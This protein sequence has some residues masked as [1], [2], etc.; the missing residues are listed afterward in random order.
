MFF[1]IGKKQ[2]KEKEKEKEREKRK[3]FILTW[4]EKWGYFVST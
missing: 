1:T 3:V 4:T 2:E